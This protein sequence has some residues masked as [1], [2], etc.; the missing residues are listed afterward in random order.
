[1]LDETP[2]WVAGILGRE[3]DALFAFQAGEAAVRKH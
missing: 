3:Q 1:M 2:D